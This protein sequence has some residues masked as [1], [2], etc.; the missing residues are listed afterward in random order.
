LERAD[1]AVIV[2]PAEVRACAGAKLIARR[3]LEGGRNPQLVV[4]GPAPGGL[5]AEEVAGA[6]GIPLLT[7]M[8]AEPDL[9]EFGEGGEFLPRPHG[10]L[11]KAARAAL[12][13]LTVQP[14]EL[15]AAS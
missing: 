5:R 2:V 13:A 12:R 9:A 14:G 15:R 10:P 1:L 6:G 4:R 8:G 3:L 11:A 7:A